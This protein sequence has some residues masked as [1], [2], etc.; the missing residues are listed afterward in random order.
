M[1]DSRLLEKERE[2]ENLREQYDELVESSAEIEKELE[3][4]LKSSE[5]KCNELSKK[6]SAIESR[7]LTLQESFESAMEE[8]NTLCETNQYLKDKIASLEHIRRDLEM[9]N[10]E[11]LDKI[12]ILEANELDLEYKLHKSQEDYCFLQNDLEDITSSSKENEMRLKAELTEL[13]AEVARLED[14]YC[15]PYQ[16]AMED[17]IVEDIHS[18]TN[19]SKVDAPIA[20]VEVGVD[21]NDEDF[22]QGSS[23]MSQYPTN[24]ELIDPLNSV[25]MIVDEIEN[26]P[27]TRQDTEE[28]SSSSDETKIDEIQIQWEAEKAFLLEELRTRQERLEATE[29]ALQDFQ[30][31]EDEKNSAPISRPLLS[32]EVSIDTDGIE[33]DRLHLL[34]SLETADCDFLRQELVK[35]VS[36]FFIVPFSSF[37][38]MVLCY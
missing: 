22:P 26:L 17:G 32:R 6:Y 15:I 8:N 9:K 1:D 24:A 20:T 33:E 35:Q 2:L 11:Y 31:R 14:L 10:T 34:D 38:F 25:D 28:I 30:S 27:E 37:F 3:S 21:T 16:Q 18:N 4:A 29:K 36:F 12:R 19:N 7:F 5:V 23:K 13:Q